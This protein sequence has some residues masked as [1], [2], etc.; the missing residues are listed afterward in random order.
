MTENEF[1][2]PD[3][4][5]NPKRK[6]P[7]KRLQNKKQRRR[8][9]KNIGKIIVN[10]FSLKELQTLLT[11]TQ[12]EYDVLKLDVQNKNI[13][14]SAKKAKIKDLKEK[15]NSYGQK[16]EAPYVSD[17]ALLRYLERVKGIDVNSIK[18]DIINDKTMELISKLGPTGTYPNGE[19]KVV[20][21]NN[22]VVTVEK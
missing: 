11:K 15:I 1:E 4:I 13:E 19:F 17:H 16:K 22:V 9:N 8:E 10:D 3:R 6:K 5:A 12:S 18:K 2:P 20:M 14:L 21:K 7:D